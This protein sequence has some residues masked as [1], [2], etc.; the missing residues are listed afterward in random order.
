[1]KQ[2][3]LMTLSLLC[4]N[5][6]A[7]EKTLIRS[8]T[9]AFTPKA[10]SVIRTNANNGNIVLGNYVDATVSP[11]VMKINIIKTDDAGNVTWNKKIN[12]SGTTTCMASAITNF[13]GNQYV[14]T[15]V[16]ETAPGTSSYRFRPIVIVIDE[17]GTVIN[18]YI[19]DRNGVG[20]T[21]KVHYGNVLVGGYY[22]DVMENH[23][24]NYREAFLCKFD[25]LLNMVWSYQFAGNVT[26]GYEHYEHVET[27]VPVGTAANPMYF[28]TGGITEHEAL[29]GGGGFKKHPN[30]LSQLID[31]NGSQVWQTSTYRG[32]TGNDAVYD[33][34]NDQFL[35]VANDKN[36]GGFPSNYF[37]IDRATGNWNQWVS[38]E[39]DVNYKPHAFH[40]PYTCKIN[41]RDDGTVKIYGYVRDYIYNGGSV[42]LAKYIPFEITTDVNFNAPTSRLLMAS[43]ASYA[44]GGNLTGN[45]PTGVNMPFI[46]P[47]MAVDFSKDGQQYF[48]L[49]GYD[50][51]SSTTDFGIHLYSSTNANDCDRF[52]NTNII[53]AVLDV[54]PWNP[55]STGDVD[56]P[57]L[58]SLAASS[59][60]AT[61]ISN[62]LPWSD[63]NTTSR[64]EREN[65]INSLNNKD[66]TGTTF[67]AHTTSVSDLSN[68]AGVSI[69]FAQSSGNLTVVFDDPSAE[70][71]HEICIYDMSGK[72]VFSE[73]GTDS[74]NTFNLS[75]YT[76]GV[77]VVNV[78]HGPTHQTQKIA[79]TR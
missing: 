39:G 32:M 49:A 75:G 7:W 45:L 19:I 26:A 21:V 78:T 37:R 31:D 50:R 40:I 22:S 56:Q 61:F 36:G 73:K 4:L 29:S 16:I 70:M 14:I 38:F 60:N 5:A 3:F 13:N 23:V 35:L 55:Y 48:T 72:L 24:C 63:G 57:T 11:Q 53:Y 27:I 28:I 66:L 76:A 30:I 47:N 20:L 64:I 46:T 1:M 43:T 18:R 9:G 6:F 44:V 41:L 54:N 77:Y 52:R 15:G 2:L 65:K 42:N 8:T 25:N 51:Y 74:L 62:C 10:Y 68:D 59:A 67:S 71:P 34:I 79:I 58:I 33:A 69:T 17:N 12:F